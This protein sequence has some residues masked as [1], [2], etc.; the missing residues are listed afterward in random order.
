MFEVIEG[1]DFE[2]L[3]KTVAC[4]FIVAPVQ[5]PGTVANFKLYRF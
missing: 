3:S 1:Q 5:K 2:Q 4:R